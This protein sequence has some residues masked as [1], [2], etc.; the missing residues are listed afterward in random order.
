[1]KTQRGEVLEI[2]SGPDPWVDARLPAFIFADAGISAHH[3]QCLLPHSE[4]SEGDTSA[5]TRRFEWEV[6][7]RLQS[8]AVPQRSCC[9]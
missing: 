6:I 7:V 8:A 4:R 9:T 5:L 2:M 3:R 1:M